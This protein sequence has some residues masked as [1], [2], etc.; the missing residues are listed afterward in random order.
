M[1]FL[2]ETVEIYRVSASSQIASHRLSSEKQRRILAAYKLYCGN[3]FYIQATTYIAQLTSYADGNLYFLP[4]FL[5]EV[6]DAG[7]RTF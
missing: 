3:E 7:L 5:T 1:P 4:D 2:R 6:D